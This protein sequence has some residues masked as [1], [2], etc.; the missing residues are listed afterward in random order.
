MDEANSAWFA[1]HARGWNPDQFKGLAAVPEMPL[2]HILLMGW[3]RVFGDSER[4]LRAINIPF[5]ALFFGSILALC[6]A[7]KQRLWWV[8]AV[9]FA[10]FPLLTYYVNESRPYVALLA[11]ST[12]AGCAL[13]MYAR[14]GRPVAAVGVLLLRFVRFRD[15]HAGRNRCRGSDVVCAD[16]LGASGT[17]FG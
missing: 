10:F 11:L 15:A 6:R 14:S 8:P 16:R 13:L 9:P 5:A 2:F 1:S 17:G 7:G 3:V 12:A 4:A